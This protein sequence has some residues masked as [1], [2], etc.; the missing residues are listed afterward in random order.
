MIEKASEW[1]LAKEQ[2]H[3]LELG[4]NKFRMARGIFSSNPPVLQ[5]FKSVDAPQG[6]VLSNQLD[7]FIFDAEPFKQSIRELFPRRRLQEQYVAIVLPDQAFHFGSFMSPPITAKMGLQA[8]LEK[9]IQRSSS[10][11]YKDYIVRYE[12]GKK[13][14]N[15]TP[16]HFCA[17]PRGILNDLLQLCN[18]TGLVPLSIQPSFVGLLRLLRMVP[19]DARQPSV[20]VHIGNETLTAGIYGNEGLRH[21]Q[22]INIGL[23]D[24]SKCLENA[25]GLE[26]D[27]ALELLFRELILLDDPTAEVQFE[28]DN[29]RIL[30]PVFADLL[31][32][33][34]GFLLLYTNEHADEAKFAKIVLSGGGARIKNLDRLIA[35]NI[36]V[37]T[38]MLSKELAA[39]VEGLNVPQNESLE[40]LAPLI[41]NMLLE[42]WRIDRHE[43]IVAA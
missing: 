19:G 9:E 11:P 10:L 32:K 28:I 36:G 4:S 38:I 14:G 1:F 35:S 23:S 12:I 41:G 31:Q 30:E 26:R 42:P 21:A 39:T 8:F 25:S 7:Q 15:K 13:T 18:D 5:L 34:Y 37:E 22:L 29:Y 20:L 43:R 27:Q 16:V 24:F 17:L 3:I 2:P 33:L 6:C 40:S